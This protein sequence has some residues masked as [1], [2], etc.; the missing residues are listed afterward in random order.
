MG[1]LAGATDDLGRCANFLSRL[2]KGG[3]FV[4]GTTV[5]GELVPPISRLMWLVEL[6][7]RVVLIPA[8]A[9]GIA[10]TRVGR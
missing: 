8:L 5:T 10:V 1:Q 3:C 6:H 9:V 4:A 7:F 2:V